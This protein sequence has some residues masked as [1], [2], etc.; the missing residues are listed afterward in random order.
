MS[1]ALQD[2]DDPLVDA[3]RAALRRAVAVVPHDDADGLAAGAI[4]LR[5]RGEPASA[6]VLLG[7]GGTPYTPGSG[8][9]DPLPPDGPL[10]ILDLGVRPLE[11]EALIVD[12][13]RPEAAAGPGQVVVSGYGERPETCTAVLM[14]R[15][16]PAQAAW[17][18]AVGAFGDLG[19]TG[20]AL[21]ETA[22]APRAAV[23]KLTPLINA[24]RRVAGGPVRMALALLVEHQSPR[25]ALADP[26]MAELEQARAEYRSEYERA[27]RTAPVIAG[28]IALLRFS[29]SS[30]VHPLVAAS[31]MRRLAPRVVIAANEHYLPGQ[32][33]FSVRGGGGRKIIELLRS[34]LPDVGG[35]FAHG[36]NR[37][38]GGSLS[39]ADF[40]RL[41]A[42]LGLPR[43]GSGGE[44][45]ERHPRTA[46]ARR[47]A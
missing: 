29:S 17:L 32:V 35:E 18:A 10:A 40:E 23:R 20:L 13:H 1:D 26:R 7:R 5:E 8:D 33:N 41:L 24:P 19:A 4:A 2:V 25:E 11:R 34:A 16:A 30:Q 27:V 43:T 46:D 3:A 28:E 22:G 6:A 9:G 45:G 14:R 47:G 44:A 36:H 39:V 21:P 42:G 31:W 37:A 12:H 15:I 38:T